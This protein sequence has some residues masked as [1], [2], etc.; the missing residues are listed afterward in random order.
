[1]YSGFSVIGWDGNKIVK[2]TITHG[3][4]EITDRTVS[5]CM[6]STGRRWPELLKE[7]TYVNVSVVNY[8]FRSKG[9]LL[10]LV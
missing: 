9:T 2:S 4:Q 5:I 3:T 10:L 7:L 6:A 8:G 1:M